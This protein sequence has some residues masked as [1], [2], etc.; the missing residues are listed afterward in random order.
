MLKHNFTVTIKESYEM[1]PFTKS[2][3]HTR[4]KNAM[5]Q[6]NRIASPY[7]NNDSLFIFFFLKLNNM[8]LNAALNS[9][10]RAVKTK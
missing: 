7:S 1:L 10:H 9:Q 5:E 3:R 2:K 6:Y 4:E 8:L